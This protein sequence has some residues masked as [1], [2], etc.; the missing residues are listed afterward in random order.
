MSKNVKEAIKEGL[1]VVVLAVIP[2]LIDSVTRGSV[3]VRLIVI[4]AIVAGLRFVDKW[5]HESETA[6]KGI[7]RF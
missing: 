4:T 1:R 2:I 3:D 5:L 6:T 7:T